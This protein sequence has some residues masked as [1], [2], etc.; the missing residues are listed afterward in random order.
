[1]QALVRTR[2][3]LEAPNA[4]IIFAPLS[5][6]L[7]DNGPAPYRKPAVG[8]GVGLCRTQARGQIGLRSK[9]PEDAPVI[10]LDLLKH[11][12]DVAQLREA[13]RLTRE[14]FTSK[15]FSPFYK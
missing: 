1:A 14:I 4:Q 6:E 15:A 11:Q 8:V 10:T 12:D 5:Y 13:M 7:T 9:N 3:G 2:E